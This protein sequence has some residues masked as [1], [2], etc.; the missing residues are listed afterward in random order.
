MSVASQPEDMARAHRRIEAILRARHVPP[1][2]VHDCTLAA[3]EV[4]AN[5]AEHAYAGQSGLAQVEIRLLEE[6]IQLRFE[7]AGPPFNPLEQ[8][9]PDLD[10]PLAA[11]P[12]GGLGILLIRHLVDRCA[13]ARE[14]STNVLTM[15]RQRP[16]EPRGEAL[17][18]TDGWG[19]EGTAELELEITEEDSGGWRVTLRGR[20]DTATAPELETALAPL[21]DSTAVSTLTFQ[22]DGL[23]YVSSAGVRC[24]VRAHRLIAGRGGRMTIVGP[25]P[26]VRGILELLKVLPPEDILPRDPGRDTHPRAARPTVR[27]RS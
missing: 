24:L 17:G 22:L 27:E 25:R 13:Y 6:E 4:M 1:E 16:L 9:A 7:D 10:A 8:P 23:G 11:R 3:E 12:V 14:G 19:K 5:I 18:A 21:L 26:P 15:S 20:L 2:T